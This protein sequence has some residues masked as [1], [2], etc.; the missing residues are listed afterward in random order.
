MLECSTFIVNLTITIDISLS[1]H[2]VDLFVSELL[3]KVCHHVT[4]L[5]GRNETVAVLVEDTERFADF[6]LAVRVLHLARHHCQ[7][8]WKVYGSIAISIYLVYLY[9]GFNVC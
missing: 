9:A 3:A 4:Q 6:L 2:F 8:L 7:E 5:S 1:D